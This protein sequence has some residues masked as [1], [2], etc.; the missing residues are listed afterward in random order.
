MTNDRIAWK[1]FA[2]AAV[3]LVAGFTGVNAPATAD[4]GIVP[5]CTTA[6]EPPDIGP[7]LVQWGAKS[8]K[9]TNASSPAK[10]STVYKRASSQSASKEVPTF[11]VGP[12]GASFVRIAAT[13]LMLELH[14]VA[15]W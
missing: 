2:F 12:A 11:G 3:V 14:I 4:S 1:T 5:G 10:Y 9:A 6:T 13:P 8:C 15:V 7:N